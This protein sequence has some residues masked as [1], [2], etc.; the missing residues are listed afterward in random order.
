MHLQ[1]KYN[2][3]NLLSG[4][5]IKIFSFTETLKST[6]LEFINNLIELKLSEDEFELIKDEMKNQIKSQLNLVPALRAYVNFFTLILK[7]YVHYHVILE[8]LENLTLKSFQE[9]YKKLF[10][11]MYIKAFIHG[12]ITPADSIETIESISHLFERHHN[13]KSI[14]TNLKNYSNLHA[15]LSGYFIFREKLYKSYNINHAVLNFYQIGKENIKN[16]I[17]ANLVKALCGYIYFTQLR[18]K[19]QLGYTA[20]A[21]IFSEGNVIYYMIVVQGS[22]KT[23]DFMDLRIENVIKLMRDRIEATDNQKFEKF[24][25]VIAKKI[26]RTDKNLKER[27]FR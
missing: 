3:Y 12:T 27:T 23:P 18:I 4:F 14:D 26:G 5:S 11:K 25:K 15:D 2:L 21:K 24:K 6:S 17:N 16:M 10:N 19:E 8:E 20:K 9:F 7:D 13:I 22:K 1:S